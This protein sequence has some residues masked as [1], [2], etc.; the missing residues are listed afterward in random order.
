MKKI[1]ILSTKKLDVS[2]IC[3]SLTMPEK[4]R[5]SIKKRA[6]IEP[7]RG[8]GNTEE[9]ASPDRDTRNIRTSCLT[10]FMGIC[11]SNESS[12]SILPKQDI[13]GFGKMKYD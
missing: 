9:I 4:R 11:Y 12:I 10:I 6:V 1:V 13:Y 5:I 2:F 3:S 7:G 8:K